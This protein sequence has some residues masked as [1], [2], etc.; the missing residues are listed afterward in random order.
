MD[1]QTDHI[2]SKAR[3]ITK[4]MLN[5]LII[6]KFI[7]HEQFFTFLHCLGGSCKQIIINYEIVLTNW[8]S[9]LLVH[10]QTKQD[11][12]QTANQNKK[13]AHL[14]VIHLGNSYVR[15]FIIDD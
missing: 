15:V 6:K 14:F 2:E 1:R 5:F 9:F 13:W 7:I 8:V 10:H 3:S 12:L 11:H 4:H